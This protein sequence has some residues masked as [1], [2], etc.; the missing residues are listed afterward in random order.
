MH[1]FLRSDQTCQSSLVDTI[2]FSAVLVL[3]RAAELAAHNENVCE[4]TDRR[5]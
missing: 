2:E 5:T 4:L 1:S 3:R